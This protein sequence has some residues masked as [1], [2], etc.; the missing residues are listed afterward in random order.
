MKTMRFICPGGVAFLLTGVMALLLCTACSDEEEGGGLRGRTIGFAVTTLRER[1]EAGTKHATTRT[2]AD[3][4]PQVEI[5][6]IEGTTDEKGRQLYLHTL[7]EEDMAA[8]GAREADAGV[9]GKSEDA[10][11]KAAPVTTATMYADATVFAAVYPSTDTWNN[12]VAPG[13]FFDLRVKKTESWSTTY[14]WPGLSKKVAFFAYAP[15]HCAG[16]TL[17]TGATTPGA[18]V[19][20]Y[21]VPAA[22]ADQTDLLTASSVDVAGVLHTPAPLKFKHALTAVRFETGTTLLPG[23]VTKITLKGVYGTAT[24]RIGN[25]VWSEHSSPKDFAQTLTTVTPDPNVP[26]SPITQPAATFMMIPQTL[27]AGAKLEVKYTDKLTNTQRTLTA[28]IAGK[29]WGMGKT[30]TYRISTSSISVTPTLEVTAPA[31]YTYQGGNNT[32]TVKSYASVS[33]GGATAN[34]PIAWEVEYSTNGGSNWSS[35]RPAWLTTFTEN[36]TGGTSAAPYTA[37]VAAQVNSAPDN[38]HTVALKNTP[39]VTNYDLSTH[40]YQGN[41]APTR[42]ANCYI[43]N[44]PGT[45]RLPLVYGNAIDKIKVPGGS[46]PGWNTSAYT[47][48]AGGGNVL[49]PFINHLGNVLTNPYIYSHAGCMPAN[50]TLVWQDAQNLVTNVALSADGHFLE[51]TV[52]QATICQGNA[53]VAVRD[54]SNTVLWSWHIWVTDYR[55]GTIGTTTPDKEI[56]NHQNKKYKIMTVNLGW[57]DGKEVIYA[58]RTVQVR[59]KQKPTAGYTSAT[60]KTFTVKQKAHTITELGNNTYYQWGRKDP[61]VGALEGPGGSSNSINKTWYDAGGNVKTN[62]LPAIQSFP[63]GTPCITRGIMNPGTFNTIWEMDYRYYNLWDANNNTTSTNDNLV[64]KTIYDPCP[65]GYKLPPSNVYT[66]FSTTGGNTGTVSQF[67][68]QGAWA[69][70]WNFYCNP[71]K[72]TSVFF[73]ASGFR[74]YNTAVP[75]HVGSFAHYCTAGPNSRGDV[76]FLIFN[77]SIVHPL[78]KDPRSFGYSVRASQE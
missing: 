10:T 47:S 8:D 69:K 43:V 40:D 49:T 30:V 11:T 32:Y 44:A 34:V 60:P 7:T 45:Y 23:T 25:T 54:A 53:V 52:G 15:H 33:G 42:T 17:T 39:P 70:G 41:P 19:F 14:H 13:Y 57:C 65:A 27:P 74:V 4:L 72:T 24:H 28:N 20:S 71:S 50:C 9:A 22:V 5:T 58:E 77:S 56:T 59:F 67:N 66:G 6:P 73:P 62:Q 16:V 75:S 29:T 37:T 61:F 18:P 38:P 78:D 1:G 2:A 48:T 21:T 46:N 76:W 68:V 35:T 51:F 55:P 12:T 64:V 63:Y 31:E 36:G 26:G 3:T